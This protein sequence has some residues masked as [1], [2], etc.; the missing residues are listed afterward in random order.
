M[1][2]LFEQ[3][4]GALAGDPAITERSLMQGR[5]IANAI[6]V[7]SLSDGGYQGQRTNFSSTYIPPE[8]PGMWVSTPRPDGHPLSALQPYWGENRGFAVQ[9][10]EQCILP[11]PPEY[12]EEEG[13]AFYTE[14]FEVYD[15]VQHLTDEQNAIALFWADDAG[16][17]ATPP[18][19]SVS[20][21]NQ[22]LALENATLDVAAEAYAKMG[23][24][25]AD[26]FILGWYYKYVY[27]P[28][29]PD[30]LHPRSHRPR[31]EY[32][33]D[34]RPGCHATLPGISVWSFRPVGCCRAGLNRPV[35]GKLRLHRPHPRR[36]RLGIAQL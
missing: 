15:A 28:H 20:I 25:Q 30:H 22:V 24:A 5:V 33:R 32:T 31:L 4:N 14:A 35:R 16:L 10:D 18:G 26:A 2:A 8:G 21:L 11:P 9:R 12:S 17:T 29:P 34:H 36:T 23:V 19:H 7:W 1:S 13:S 27:N 6:L 3:W